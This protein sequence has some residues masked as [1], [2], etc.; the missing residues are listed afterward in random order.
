MPRA[1]WTRPLAAGLA[2]LLLAAC[3]T[4]HLPPISVAGRDFAPE[5]D[6]LALW[7]ES[8]AEEERL[9]AAVELYDDP[10]L[11]AY[12]DEL[13]VALAPPGLAANREI[14]LAAHVLADPTLNAFAYP[15][16]SLYLHTGILA[17]VEDEA[18]LATVLAHELSHVEG[19]HLLRHRRAAQNREIGF[20]IAA[21]AASVILAEAVGEELWKG[22][23]GEAALLDL[24][25]QLAI[26]LG[27]Q[28]ALVASV[29]GYGRDLER[30]ADDGAVR[31]LRR[32]GYDLAAAPAVYQA[33]LD[34]HGER[35]SGLEQYFFGSHPRLEERVARSRETL[36]AHPPAEAPRAP[37]DP[38]RFERL[39]APLVRDDARLNLGLGRLELAGY[40]LA[41]ARRAL[42]G[43]AE[44]RY[45]LGLL[46]LA[47]AEEAG[48]EAE[49][50]AHRDDARGELLQAAA[51]AP[52]AGHAGAHRELAHLALGAGDR[53]GACAHLQSALDADPEQEGA[54]E[55]WDLL[56]SLAA[57]GVCP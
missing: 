26:G 43:D 20:A 10:A 8:R 49:A 53:A 36:L 15:H 38:E 45:L 11:A 22:D 42:P 41:R 33:L 51:L 9:L 47:R 30:E 2:A 46:A 25:G 40:E 54:A 57:E 5:G 19:R 16:G 21:V 17:R 3:A 44:T 29:N 50:A 35:A 52:G 12:L 55:L 31:L 13:L 14:E 7:A 39:L 34:D 48:S 27:L 37:A 32:A 1:P 24:F 23:W 18:Q 6:E 28:L 4:P 56:D